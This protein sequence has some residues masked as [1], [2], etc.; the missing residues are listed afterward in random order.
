MKKDD[1]IFCKIVAGEAPSY[2]VWE[3]DSHFAFLSIFPNTEGVTVVIPKEHHPSYIFGVPE[4][5]RHGLIESAKTVALLLDARLTDVGRTGMIFEGFGVDHLH[6]KL[7]PM[8]GTK[9]MGAWKPIE[10]KRAEFYAAYP[11]FLSSHDAGRADDED[12]SSLAERI[13]TSQ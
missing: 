7:Y 13:R 10:S 5:V 11:G 6:A 3:S 9:D 1:C 8:H 2:R 12:L 4:K